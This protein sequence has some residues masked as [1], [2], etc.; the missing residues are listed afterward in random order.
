MELMDRARYLLKAGDYSYEGIPGKKLAEAKL[1]Q[2]R[3]T[4]DMDKLVF[5][6]DFV[7]DVLVFDHDTSGIRE[8]YGSTARNALLYLRE[9]MVLDD[10]ANV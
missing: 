5:V 2:V 9:K 6:S 3:I 4:L 7:A 8:C 1:G 10:L